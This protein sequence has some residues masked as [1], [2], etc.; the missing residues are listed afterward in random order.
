VQ[1][2]GPLPERF[3]TLNSPRVTAKLEDREPQSADDRSC[4]ALVDIAC[5]AY[6]IGDDSTAP[7]DQACWYWFAD[8]VADQ[9]AEC[10]KR[11]SYLWPV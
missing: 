6:Q 8:S 7:D 10:L 9:A 4:E 2:L 11:V 3:A 5:A 1:R